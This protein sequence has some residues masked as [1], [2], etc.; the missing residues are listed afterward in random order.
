MFTRLAS[1]MTI[2]IGRPALM[3]DLDLEL[4]ARLV[5]L[6]SELESFDVFEHMDEHE[7]CTIPGVD[8]I[9]DFAE[10]IA[11]AVRRVA[12]VLATQ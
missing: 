6:L 12:Y 9:E 7:E 3:S 11:F 1:Q 5:E 2:V 8:F 10:G 4:R